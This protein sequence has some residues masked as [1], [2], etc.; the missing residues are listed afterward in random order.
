MMETL[1]PILE[2]FWKC[3]DDQNEHSYSFIDLQYIQSL[4]SRMFGEIEQMTPEERKGVWWTQSEI[5][6]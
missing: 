1:V 2:S 5:F 4:A 6:S 3:T